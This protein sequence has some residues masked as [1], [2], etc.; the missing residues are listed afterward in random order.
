MKQ[1]RKLFGIILK[2]GLKVRIYAPDF[3]EKY[4]WKI[5][6]TKKCS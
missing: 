3:I 2:K 6:H 1:K 4:R 5:A